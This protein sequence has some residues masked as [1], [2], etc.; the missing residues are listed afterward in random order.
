[1]RHREESAKTNETLKAGP[2][3]TQRQ[4]PYATPPRIVQDRPARTNSVAALCDARRKE[5]KSVIAGKTLERESGGGM[6]RRETA[7][8]KRRYAHF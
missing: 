8:D 5:E 6:G 2:Q 3:R 4:T 7:S 1:M